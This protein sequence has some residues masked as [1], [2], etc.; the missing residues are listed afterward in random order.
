MIE[1]SIE[2]QDI[3]PN[4]NTYREWL[5]KV[6]DGFNGVISEINY[7]L[8]TDDVLWDLNKTYLNHDYYTDIL[9]FDRT[10]GKHIA[11]DVYI[12]LDRVSENAEEYEVSFEEEL[13]RVMAHGLL[14]MLGLKD[15]NEEEKLNMRAAE[16]AALKLFHVKQ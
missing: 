2:H 4:V 5:E 6:V 9:T 13:R 16:T 7:I 15:S 1:F 12:S 3:N 10:E 8:T 11:G 14:H